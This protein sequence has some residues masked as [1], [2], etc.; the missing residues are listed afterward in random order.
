M[1]Q[2]PHLWFRTEIE[3]QQKMENEN[4]EAL[5]QALGTKVCEALN[6]DSI[7]EVM[8]NDDGRLWIERGS[9]MVHVGE[10][11]RNNALTTL[12][13]MAHAVN[14]EL[15]DQNPIISGEMPLNNERFE[16]VAPPVVA[17]PVFAIRKP[18]TRIYT[19][20]DYLKNGMPF[21]QIKVLKSAIDNQKNILVVGGTGSGKT[22][23]TNCLLDYCAES[24]A[25]RDTRMLILQDTN[26]L[27]CALPNR[28]FLRSNKFTSLGV[29][30]MSANRLRPD[31]ITVGEVRAG[32]PA[33]DLLKLWNTGHPGG[34]ATVHANSAYGGLTRLDQL[35]Q[36]VSSYPQRVLIGEAINIVVFMARDEMDG[37]RIRRAKEIIEVDCY[38]PVAQRFIVR[39]LLK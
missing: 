18:A 33:L 30:S 27:Q 35:I 37:F 17:S 38:D 29:L 19:F 22:T 9:E 12:R 11:N 23:F 36:E 14:L 15:N 26:E 34:F 3:S 6:D 8:L 5:R 39:N 24:L 10:M 21:D 25:R 13:L 4:V 31:S 20:N 2:N 16:G 32:G 7:T 28:I 1:Q